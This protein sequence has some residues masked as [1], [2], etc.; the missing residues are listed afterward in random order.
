MPV[1]VTRNGE[2][3]YYVT[4]LQGDV[5]GIVD[6]NG[7]AVAHYTYDAWGNVLRTH[8]YTYT[9]DRAMK[10]IA[11][12]TDFTP[13]AIGFMNPLRYR[14]YIYDEYCTYTDEDNNGEYDT[15]GLYYLQSRFYNP[16]WGRFLTAGSL[17]STR[18][19][20]INMTR[21]C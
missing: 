7:I 13:N 20:Y 8:C 4:N 17:N 16:E 19:V 6:K 5:V 15:F 18:L 10:T 1:S 9:Y 21:Y 3:Y 14:G 11:Y 12:T 2:T